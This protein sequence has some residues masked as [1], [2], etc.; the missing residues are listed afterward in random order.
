ME[1][2]KAVRLVGEALETLE[3]RSAKWFLDRPVSN[4]GRLARRISD[5]AAGYGWPWSVEVVLNP[6]AAIL[7]SNAVAVTSDSLILDG[8]A[9]WINFNDYLVRH[10]L[11]E[12]WTV[13]LRS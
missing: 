4:S 2:E 3:P 13:D 5:L 9:G 1:T 11:P 12:A 7:S 10:Y 8:A 6:D